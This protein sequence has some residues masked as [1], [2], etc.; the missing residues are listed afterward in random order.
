MSAPAALQRQSSEGATES[1][2][3][4]NITAKDGTGATCYAL[5]IRCGAASKNSEKAAHW[6]D[7]AASA[8]SNTAIESE[9]PDAIEKLRR[10]LAR[11]EAAQQ[12]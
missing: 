9:T 7:R 4:Q 3:R 2:R 1:S 12:R 8:A 5:T 11:C 6:L 10:Q